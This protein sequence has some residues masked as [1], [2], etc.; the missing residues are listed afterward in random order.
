MKI[1]VSV[2]LVVK[3]ASYLW[4]GWAYFYARSGHIPVPYIV[5]H[6]VGVFNALVLL[7]ALLL[8]FLYEPTP[9]RTWWSIVISIPP[10]VIVA[11]LLVVLI[12]HR[13][14]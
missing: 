1:M 7:G 11:Y 3:V 12:I 14:F 10:I 4:L 9:P 8:Y 2:I 13:Y 6:I 5:A